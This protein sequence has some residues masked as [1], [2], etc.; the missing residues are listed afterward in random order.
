MAFTLS[1]R[2]RN[3]AGGAGGAGGGGAGGCG[4]GSYGVYVIGQPAQDYFAALAA[5]A[6]GWVLRRCSV[7]ERVALIVGGLAL[8]YPAPASD[9]LGIVAVL[10]VLA[11]QKLRK[12]ALR[13]T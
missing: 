1:S 10:A 13:A 11:W 6:Q 9:V 7:M 4:G 5:G 8:V 3:P 2:G 12:P